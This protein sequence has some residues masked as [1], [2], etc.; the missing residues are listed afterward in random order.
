MR[1]SLVRWITLAGAV[2]IVFGVTV[3]LGLKL[4]PLPHTDTDYLAIGSAATLLSLLALF[5]ALLATWLKTKHL[6]Y[7]RRPVSSP[8]G[9][10]ATPP[11]EPPLADTSPS[12]DRMSQS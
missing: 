7:I 11:G 6:L 3:A 5:A 1:R 10:E 4:I 2:I 9:Q 12:S 8:F